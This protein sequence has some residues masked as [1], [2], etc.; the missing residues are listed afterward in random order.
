MIVKTMKGEEEGKKELEEFFSTNS[1]EG[2]VEYTVFSFRNEREERKALFVLPGFHLGPLKGLGGSR[3]PTILDETVKGYEDVFTFH[4]P[5]THALNPVREEDSKR[6]P[7]SINEDLDEMEYSSEASRFVRIE[8]EGIVGGQ[9]F[10]SDLLLNL[11]FYPEPT[12]DV[13]ASVGKIISQRGESFSFSQVGVIDSHNCGEKRVNGVFYPSKKATQI[14]GNSERI[15]EKVDSL[16]RKDLKMGTSSNKDYDEPGIGKEGIKVAVFE[17]KDQR[18]AQILVDANNMVPVLRGDIQEEIE[19]MV[20]ISEVHTSDTHEVNTLLHSHEPLG[21]NFS[22]EKIIREIK[23]LVKE[24]VKDIESVDVAVSGGTLKNIELMGP[25]NTDRI[26]AVSET[27]AKT[28]PYAV[29]LTF[30]LQ[31][32]LTILVS[33]ALL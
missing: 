14:I 21:N 5:S 12:E 32:V 3:L 8:E 27:L 33:W 26:N 16:E 19:D 6:L 22:K 7:R 23:A 18:S 2:E 25:V 13:H 29:T 11:S 24:A 15:F 4:V 30:A 31:F 1:V 20:D 10:G 28:L 9:S 17:V